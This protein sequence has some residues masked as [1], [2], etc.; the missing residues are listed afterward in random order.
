MEC[1]KFRTIDYV[2]KMPTVSSEKMPVLIYLHGAGARR[3]KLEQI[4]NHEFFQRSVMAGEDSPLLMVAPLCYANSWF[5]MFEELQRF[6]NM[7]GSRPD[8]DSKRVYLMGASMGG[9]GTWQLAMT[10][11]DLFAAIVPICGGGMYWDAYQLR[12]TPVWAWHGV[13]DPVVKPEETI[14]M[15]A[16]I[17][18]HADCPRARLTMLENAEHNAWSPA[19]A[20]RELM[21]WLLAQTKCDEKID[22]KNLFEGTAQ[23]G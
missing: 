17:N 4:V 20:S 8:V 19:F 13:L 6:V 7:I 3:G 21:D 12:T 10:L 1:K 23:F 5:E 18:A 2:E 22:P 15:V 14:K 9:Y 11:P 16:A